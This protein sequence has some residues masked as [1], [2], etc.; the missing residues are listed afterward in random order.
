MGIL[1]SLDEKKEYTLCPAGRKI[2]ILY[3]IIDLGTQKFEYKGKTKFNRKIMIYFE[4][5]F[6]TKKFRED[7]EKKPFIISKKFT[8]SLNEKSNLSKFLN[9][10]CDGQF[11]KKFKSQ[12]ENGKFDITRLIGAGGLLYIQHNEYN[13]KKYAS[14]SN[15]MPLEKL[16]KEQLVLEENSKNKYQTVNEKKFFSLDGF[17]KGNF[18]LEEFEK[19]PEW[20]KEEISK[21][22]E[23]DVLFKKFPEAIGLSENYIDENLNEEDTILNKDEIPF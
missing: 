1:I 16:E 7:E 15:I 22:K 21:S 20:I 14:I 11:I 6:E 10:W 8:L 9:D 12:I 19:L 17:N 13:E 2:G 18:D 5:P 3:Q 4:L 23:Y